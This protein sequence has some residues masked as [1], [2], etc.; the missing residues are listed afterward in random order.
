MF[1]LKKV[2]NHGDVKDSLGELVRAIFAFE[3][4]V[5]MFGFLNKKRCIIFKI[6]V[7][8]HRNMRI[9]RI[10]MEV[11]GSSVSFLIK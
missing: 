3:Y 2:N 5:F 7:L 11:N 6:L 10:H 1:R 8:K 4:K 9:L